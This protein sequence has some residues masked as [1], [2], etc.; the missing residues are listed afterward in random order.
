M[1]SEHLQEQDTLPL[2]IPKP[3]GM[4]VWLPDRTGQLPGVSWTHS[5]SEW[6]S[7][8][9]GFSRV[10][11]SEILQQIE[12]DAP[13][14]L[15]PKACQGILRRAAKRGKK[16]PDALYKALVAVAA[17]SDLPEDDS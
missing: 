15:S 6:P 9:D 10:L 4:Q 2:L 16:L 1:S 12:P 14:W 7:D 13:Y 11:L 8:D 3:D 17:K 5:T